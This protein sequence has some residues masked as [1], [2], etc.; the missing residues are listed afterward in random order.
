MSLL[1][2]TNKTNNEEPKPKEEKPVDKP[3]DESTSA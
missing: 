3:A 1:T 2:T